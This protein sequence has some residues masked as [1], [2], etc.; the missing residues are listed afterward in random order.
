[1]HCQGM[2]FFV[3]P[4]ETVF[5][6]LC[7]LFSRVLSTWYSIGHHVGK[8]MCGMCLL[9]YFKSAF[10]NRR[11]RLRRE[12]FFFFFFV[13]YSYS[14]SITGACYSLRV[15]KT[16]TFPFLSNSVCI[17]GV[18]YLQVN[19]TPYPVIVYRRVIFIYGSSICIYV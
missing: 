5:F 6:S 18:L 3:R 9:I 8:G 7:I 19:A 15:F 16:I 2:P 13:R 17:C 11:Y 10:N 14:L 4:H 12:F 1:M